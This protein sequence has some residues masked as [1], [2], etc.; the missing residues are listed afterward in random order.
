M[1]VL[2]SNE[3]SP[4]LLECELDLAQLYPDPL[5]SAAFED[6]WQRFAASNAESAA[7]Y[8]KEN[9]RLSYW[10]ESFVRSIADQGSNLRFTLPAFERP[11]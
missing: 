11:E 9:R 5:T 7:L 2:K 8:R 10:S 4:G 3:V 6:R 1:P